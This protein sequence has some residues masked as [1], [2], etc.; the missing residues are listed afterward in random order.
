VT[1]SS[2]KTHNEQLHEMQPA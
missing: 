2:K 1:V